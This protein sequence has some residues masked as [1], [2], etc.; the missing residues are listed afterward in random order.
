MEAYVFDERELQITSM[1][2][3][4]LYLSQGTFIGEE[5][6]DRIQRK[7]VDL[8]L[9]VLHTQLLCEAANSVK[10]SGLQ[11]IGKSSTG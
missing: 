11:K 1:Y 3:E 4:V 6:D 5:H 8:L 2:T 10:I 7:N 9:G